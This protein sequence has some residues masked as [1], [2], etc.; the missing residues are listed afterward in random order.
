MYRLYPEVR[1]VVTEGRNDARF[2]KYFLN[3]LPELDEVE[4]RV[5]AVGDRLNLPDSEVIRCGFETGARGRVLAL[6]KIC[7]DWPDELRRCLT[8]IADADFAH[9]KDDTPDVDVLLLTDYASM[10]G[11][12]LTDRIMQKFLSVG[13]NVDKP[14]GSELLAKVVPLLNELYYLRAA[15][16]WSRLGVS[17]NENHLKKT[18]LEPAPELPERLLAKCLPAASDAPM[19]TRILSEAARIKSDL[20]VED[21]IKSVRGHDISIILVVVLRLKNKWAD[22]EIVERTLMTCIEQRDLSSHQ[23]FT[24]L[25]ERVRAS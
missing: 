7:A 21:P 18:E 14:T 5:Y 1:D 24:R 20:A 4:Y 10:E 8:C 11:Y 25:V 17:L 2:I 13:L 16:H 22:H 15:L 9:V 6:A 19:R 23:L 3:G 12:A